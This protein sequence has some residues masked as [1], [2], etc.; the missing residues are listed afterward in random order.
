MAI[1]IKKIGQV[2]SIPRY[3]GAA[4]GDL[5]SADG[6]KVDAIGDTLLG[7]LVD[8]VPATNPPEMLDVYGEGSIVEDD[9]LAMTKGGLVYSDGDGTWS[10]TEPAGAAGTTVAVMGVALSATEVEMRLYTY[11]KGA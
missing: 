10:Q 3:A 4:A 8:E 5:V 11:E 9:A 1:K 7:M 6:A 2:H